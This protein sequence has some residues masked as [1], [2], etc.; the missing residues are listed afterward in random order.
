MLKK[1]APVRQVEYNG[2]IW[3][4]DGDNN[5]WFITL[6]DLQKQIDLENSGI[7]DHEDFWEKY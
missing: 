1:V 2:K 5:L 7:F 3:M 4:L 6:E